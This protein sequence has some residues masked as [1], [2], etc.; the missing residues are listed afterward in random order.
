[1]SSHTKT[2]LG[3]SKKVTTMSNK[4]NPLQ[5]NIRA[6]DYDHAV[7]LAALVFIELTI[8]LNAAPDERFDVATNFAEK[9]HKDILNYIRKYLGDPYDCGEPDIKALIKSILEEKDRNR[10]RAEDG[11]MPF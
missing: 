9:Y 10:M 11:D 5:S 6:F 7:E 4:L 2:S 1:M 8:E 3:C